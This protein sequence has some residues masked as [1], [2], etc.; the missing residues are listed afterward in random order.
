MISDTRFIKFIVVGVLNTLFGYSCYWIFLKIGVHYSLAVLFSTLLGVVF[1]FKTVGRFVF[2]SESSNLIYRFISVYTILYFLNVG[3]I[4][5]ICSL[6][7]SNEIAGALML[8]PMAI[9][10]FYLNKKMVFES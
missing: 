7:F 10:G 3:S 6:G 1:N 2:E 4:G 9:L 5:L 8:I